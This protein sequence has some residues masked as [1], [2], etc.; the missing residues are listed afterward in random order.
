MTKTDTY[1][2]GCRAT[3]L[4]LLIAGESN[5]IQPLWTTVWQ[6][7]KLYM[8]P[9]YEL[10]ILLQHNYLPKGNEWLSMATKRVVKVFS[11][12]LYS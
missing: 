8:H 5:M 7:T 3:G 9:P 4:F 12:H 1:W 6:L 11:Q 2:G 10:E